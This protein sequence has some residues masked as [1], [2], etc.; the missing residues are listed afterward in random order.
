MVKTKASTKKATGKKSGGTITVDDPVLQQTLE[1]MD[2]KFGAGTISTNGTGGIQRQK[3]QIPSGSIGLDI[4]IGPLYRDAKGAWHTGYGTGRVIECFG[5][6]GTGKTTLTLVTIANAQR[7]GKVCAFIDAEHN[8]DVNYAKALGVDM[9]KL[10][11]SQPSNGEEALQIAEALVRS[12][13]VQL[14]VIDSVAALI[15]KSELEGEVG[16]SSMG[17]QARMM[18]QAL[19]KFM[20]LLGSGVEC[21]VYFTNQIRD[22]IGVVFGNPETTPG[23]RALKFAAS[24]RID[25]RR[26]QN[27]TDDNGKPVGHKMKLKLIKNKT[28]SPFQ[29]TTVDLTWGHGIDLHAELLDLCVESQIVTKTPGHVHIFRGK[30]FGHGRANAIL[31]LRKDNNLAYALYDAILTRAL[32]MRGFNPDLSPIDGFVQEVSAAMPMVDLF[33]PT[34]KVSPFTD[35]PEKSDADVDDVDDEDDTV[36]S[37]EPA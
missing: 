21:T 34:D 15:P 13:R 3:S 29:E 7:Q 12:R 14:I 25:V 9:S 28:G 5:P 19:R 35:D 8:L 30:G 16:D 32:A 18:S 31:E 36:L 24:Y 27:I 10:L 4:L 33:D 37:G 11:L 1:A 23:G 6:E 20:N 17:V 22:K 26:T 2:K